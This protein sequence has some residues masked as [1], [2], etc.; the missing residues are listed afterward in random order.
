[1]VIFYKGFDVRRNRSSVKAHH[2]QLAL[3]GTPLAGP[4]DNSLTSSA[5]WSCITGQLATSQTWGLRNTKQET[6][7][8]PVEV[9]PYG[10]HLLGFGRHDDNGAR[11]KRVWTRTE[12]LLGR[13]SERDSTRMVDNERWGRGHAL[14]TVAFTEA[15]ALMTLGPLAVSPA[16]WVAGDTCPS[17]NAIKRRP[18]LRYHVQCYHGSP[19]RAASHAACYRS[20]EHV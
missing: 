14:A 2:E 5:P 4:T 13:R 6:A 1:V 7:D 17:T 19:S 20:P 15:E 9:I 12:D 10:I 11:R 18:P 3:F 8:A 16:L